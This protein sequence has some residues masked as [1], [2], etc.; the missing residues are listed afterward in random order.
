MSMDRR[1]ASLAAAALAVSVCVSA[2]AHAAA[3]MEVPP[4]FAMQDHTPLLV[5][6]AV[7]AQIYAC[8][9]DPT[10]AGGATWRFREPIAALIQDGKTIGRHYA[11]PTWALDDGSSVTGKLLASAPGASPGDI[12][13]LKLAVAAH[14]GSG[15][16]GAAN[17][18]L[19][20]DTHGGDLRG[21]CATPG[22]LRAEPYS[23]DYAFYR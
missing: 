13:R 3:P 1:T 12:T 6:H 16:L 8:T 5:L 7:G 23:A 4:A 18:V 19:R 17:V 21:A 14:R 2:G 11:G 15:Q 10:S 20:L 9:A 22:E